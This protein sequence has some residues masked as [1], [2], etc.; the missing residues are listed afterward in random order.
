MLLFIREILCLITLR[1]MSHQ[2][3]IFQLLLE[4]RD[5][6][7][8]TLGK[9]ELGFAFFNVSFVLHVALVKFLTSGRKQVLN[10]KRLSKRV[11]AAAVIREIPKYF[12][13]SNRKRKSVP[14]TGS[15]DIR[16]WTNIFQTDDRC[17]ELS[18]TA[19]RA[20]SL[21]T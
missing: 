20:F 10:H 9:K 8:T 7:E 18:W 3:K 16:L 4:K 13:T 12:E 11:P 1:R 19:P 6:Q 5:F 17:P 2:A 15:V 21:A 14:G